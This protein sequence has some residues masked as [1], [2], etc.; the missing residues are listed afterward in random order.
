MAIAYSYRL[1]THCGVLGTRFDGRPFYVEAVDPS[2]VT[3]GLDN[4]EDLGTMTLVSPHLAVF[5]TSQGHIIQF[6]DSPPG[7]VG[8]PYPFR[9]LVLSGGNQLIDRQFAGRLWRAQGSIP[10][11]VGPPYGN[12]QDRFTEVDGTITLIAPDTAA[13][14][15]AAGAQVRFVAV[16]PGGCD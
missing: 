13:F 11:V 1:H 4:P 6:V 10:G 7:V 5:V 12:G 3:T 2:T 15:S 9:V 16:E 14:R 8:Q